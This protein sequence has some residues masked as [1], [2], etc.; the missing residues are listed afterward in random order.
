MGF[1]DWLLGDDARER[2]EPIS[3]VAETI[4]DLIAARQAAFGI[5]EALAMPAVA[6]AVQLITNTCAMF[7]PVVYRDGAPAAYQPRVVSRPSPFATRY[8][9]IAQSVM[10]GIVHG[11]TYWLLG[12]RDPEGWARV[13][14]VLDPA[15]VQVSWDSKRLAEVITW[16]ERKLLPGTDVVHIAWNRRPGEVRGRS[17]L[18]DA[19]PTLATLQAAEDFASSFFTTAGVPSVILK[20][21]TALTKE[22]AERLKI[23]WMNAHT[24]PEATPAVLSGGIEADF[25]GYDPQRSQLQE[26]RSYAATVIARLFGIPA[27]LLHVETSGATITYMNGQAAFDGFVQ[28]TVV[29]SY[30]AP[31][32]SAW[33]DLVPQGNTV[34]FDTRDLMR[35]DT[36][37]RFRVYGDAIAAGVMTTT[38]ARRLEGWPVDGDLSSALYAPLATPSSRPVSIPE[39]NV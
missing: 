13:A 15:E 7:Q 10:S 8:E 25:P 37:A 12:D 6:R 4:Y 31:I 28:T 34:R 29:P 26:T 30:L 39:G 1:L 21:S 14:L 3:N 22:E 11:D 20:S 23:A 2:T 9:W 16:R 24:G 36:A 19:L 27:P 32:E 38:E 17:L 35:L 33:S 5:Q 18:R